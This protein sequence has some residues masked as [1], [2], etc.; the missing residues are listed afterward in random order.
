[1]L[2][3][4]SLADELD[5][6]QCAD[7]RAQRAQA[8]RLLARQTSAG[9]RL[10]PILI[11]GETTVG[12]GLL[13]RS[14]HRASS[15]SRSPLIEVNCAAISAASTRESSSVPHITSMSGLSTAARPS[16]GG[17]GCGA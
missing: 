9:G 3:P 6:Y 16:R 13:V 8:I 5:R 4:M 10:L 12:K 14:L 17:R 7:R 1:M 15:L 2:A 11:L